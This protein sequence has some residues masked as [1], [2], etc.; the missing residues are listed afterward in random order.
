[1]LNLQQQ[2]QIVMQQLEDLAT[3]VAEPVKDSSIDFEKLLL[4]AKNNPFQYHIV[5]QHD[6]YVKNLYLQILMSIVHQSEAS[7]ME[8][9]SL[10]ARIYN[11][12]GMNESF[13]SYVNKSKTLT[14][15]DVSQFY[16]LLKEN[17][18]TEV[19]I[20]DSLMIL[21][22]HQEKRLGEYVAELV[23]NLDISE[24]D[25]NRA[26]HIVKAILTVN[27]GSIHNL[28]E[29]N[30]SFQLS[31][32]HYLTA[33]SSKFAPI[34]KIVGDGKTVVDLKDYY[35]QQIML[36]KVQIK[37]SSK[38]PLSAM[39]K[40]TLKDCIFFDEDVKLKI[41]GIDEVIIDNLQFPVSLQAI[42]SGAYL[43][44]H[45]IEIENVKVIQI[46]NLQLKNVKVREGYLFKVRHVEQFTFSKNNFEKISMQL[47]IISLQSILNYL[48]KENKYDDPIAIISV[49]NTRDFI[50][51][52]NNL[53]NCSNFNGRNYR[54]LNNIVFLK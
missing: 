43:P 41:V 35:A 36:E 54:D 4:E 11:N 53:S 49:E 15:Q 9:Y 42:A 5:E 10:V 19:F 18:L 32:G 1:M 20:I 26:C 24:G 14:L 45:S 39:T 3:Q 17:D 47:R 38:S 46:N 22:I 30:R 6:E 25:F 13:E 27:H 48:E 44:I 34:I 52:N 33:I 28:F 12:F 31:V 50:E 2:I 21:G 16:S 37:N 51:S 23:Y 29:K 40:I 7:K 8:R